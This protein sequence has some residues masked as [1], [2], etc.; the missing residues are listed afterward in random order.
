MPDLM[1]PQTNENDKHE[2]EAGRRFLYTLTKLNVPSLLKQANIRKDTRK[3]FGE[4]DSGC[5]SAYTVFTFL[6]MLVFQG[7]NLF[8]YLASKK[9]DCAC[10]KNTYY[11]FLN[12]CHFNWGR[13]IT[14]L[15]AKVVALIEPLTSEK[16]EKCFVLDDS[17]IERSRSKTVELL[18]RVYDHVIGKTVR[19]FN[20]LTLGWTDH[21]SFIPVGFNM[22]SS[23]KEKNRITEIDGQIDK[24]TTGY[25]NRLAAIM[26]KPDAAIAL[27]RNALNAG[28][29]ARYLLMDTWFTVEPFIKRVLAEGLD[30]IGML[31]DN[32]QQ[33][34][35]RG[36]L[37]GLRELAK[38]ICFDSQKEIFG[39]VSVKT[40]YHSISV[41]LVFVRNRNRKNEYIVI[42]ATDRSLSDSEVVRYYGSRWS[43]EC[44][45]KVCKSLLKLGEEFHGVGYDMTIS[46]TAIVFTR[47]ILL[48]WIRREDA[49]PR[50][51]GDLFFLVYDEV[52]DI[53]LTD[54][55]QRLLSIFADGVQ[56]GEITISES[57]RLLLIDWFLSQ[58]G[59]IRALF[60][61]FIVD[62]QLTVAEQVSRSIPCQ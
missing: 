61:S 36:R 4:K 18:A 10:S 37:Y 7:Q 9:H 32:K 1:I 12:D 21:Y 15:S 55:L 2:I 13:F 5:R 38:F 34:W 50:T 54:A 56:S 23:A 19:G 45:F 25:Q 47:Y 17:V 3:L 14:L 43:I 28:I 29:A 42:L 8:R 49:D 6:I 51:M 31:K 40:K 41:K 60:P 48:E 16:R 52:K 11:R 27:I 20:L 59:F 39:S 33:Y 62:S 24:R 46:T 22:M 35:Y 53:E 58:P 44:C 57:V 30:V 26:Q